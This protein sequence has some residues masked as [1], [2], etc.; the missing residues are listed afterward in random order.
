MKK[1]LLMLMIIGL[2]FTLTGCWG[3]KE[4]QSQIYVTGIGIDYDKDEFTVYIQAMNFANIAKQEG[5]SSLQ[6]SV[7]V[8]IG[9]S[10]G[11]TIQA[12]ISKL[13]QKAAYPLY[14]GHAETILLS[15][16]AIKEKVKSVIEYIGQDPF[17]RYNSNFFGTTQA[18]KDVFNSESFF[19]YPS[20]YTVIYNPEVLN[21]NNFIIP[22]QR[23][24]KFIATYYEPVGSFI[25]PGIEINQTHYSEGKDSKQ[26]PAITGGFVISNQENKGWIDKNDL[27]GIKWTSNEATIIPLTLFDEKVSV[28]IIKPNKVIRVLKGN[29]PT[30]ELMVRGRAE[31]IQNEDNIG[32]DKIEKELSKKVKSDIQKTLEMG[33]EV[34]ADLLNISEKAYRYHLNEWDAAEI[35]SFDL[36]SIENIDVKI[37]IEKSVNYKR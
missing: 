32:I 27:S 26:I 21:R 7:P 10:K 6:E 18:I 20:L 12:A 11:K 5:A 28:L 15:E 31:L 19:N 8:F 23:Y 24:N 35:K 9:E 30:Y 16:N 17:L 25:I 2:L 36:T 4:I 1:I 14:F 34:K 29:K 22:V 37:K 33:D 13:E 3:K